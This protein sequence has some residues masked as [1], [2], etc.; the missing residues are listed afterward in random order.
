MNTQRYYQSPDH[1]EQDRHWRVKGSLGEDVER[2]R[3]FHG[4]FYMRDQP[5]SD[6]FEKLEQVKLLG[7]KPAGLPIWPEFRD[8]L[9]GELH[10][11][12]PRRMLFGPSPEE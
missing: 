7:N 12:D 4:E 5:W 9:I 8:S 11:G 6:M 1:I 2:A 10:Q 3:A